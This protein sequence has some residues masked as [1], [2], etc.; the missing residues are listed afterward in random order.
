M[1][2]A[3]H[4][5]AFCKDVAKNKEIWTIQFSDESYI[6]WENSEGRDVFPVWS[7][8]SRV[9]KILSYEEEFEGAVPV[10]FSLDEFISDWMPTLLENTTGLGPNWA[11]E[12]LMGWEMGAQE[13]IDRILKQPEINL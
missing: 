7:T 6:K 10:C 11:G 2:A 8:K 12:N 9:K 13:V 1:S 3:P 5:A 4:V